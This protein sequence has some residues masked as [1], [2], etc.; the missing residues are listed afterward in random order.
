MVTARFGVADFNGRSSPGLIPAAAFAALAICINL[1]IA[2]SLGD[3]KA[4]VVPAP[5]QPVLKVSL[6]ALKAPPVHTPPPAPP[7]AVSAA[8][9]APAPLPSIET[10]RTAIKKLAIARQAN[11]RPA[12]AIDRPKAKPHTAVTP[13]VPDQKPAAPVPDPP[14]PVQKRK[15]PPQEIPRP[16]PVA[17]AKTAEPVKPVPAPDAPMRKTA[18]DPDPDPNRTSRDAS[19]VVQDASYRRQTPPVYPRRALELGQQGTVLLHTEILPTGQVKT[20]KVVQSSGH[21]LLDLSALAAVRTWEFEP[22][23]INGATVTS[24]VRVPVHFVIQ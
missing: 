19:H 17:E 20:L 18:P 6:R 10:S 5:E 24:W 11:T 7:P 13:K 14:A 12:P 4:P 8:D 21:R 15:L 1:A 2:H 23:H 16:H 3:I 22:I 9:A